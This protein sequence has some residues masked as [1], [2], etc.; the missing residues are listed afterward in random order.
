M[1]YL[2]RGRKHWRTMVQNDPYLKDVL[3][4]PPLVAYK[5]PPN[6]K[7][8][9]IRA[10]VPPKSNPRPKRTVP[11]M[12]KCNRCPICPFVDPGK[13]VQST[14]NNHKVQINTQVRCQTRNLIYCISCAK[15]RVQY[16]GETDRTLQERFSEHKGYVLNK[17]LNKATGAH[18]NLPGHSVA[19]MKVTI[20]E[21]VYS[22]DGMIRQQR[23]KMFI[24]DLNTNYK[25]LNRKG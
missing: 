19:D 13:F 21:K 5:R 25:G 17:H 3:P 16:V 1:P 23:E 18:F 2:S 10:K 22:M 24:A 6:I 7:D 15:C 8:I 20:L 14:A 11:G 12:Q 4:L 9:L